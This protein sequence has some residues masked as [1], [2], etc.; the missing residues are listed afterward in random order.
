MEIALFDLPFIDIN[1]AK[2]DRVEAEH[3]T[4][5]DL[6]FDTERIDRKA[7]IDHANNAVNGI[8]AIISD[9]DFDRISDG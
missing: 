1:R 4:A 8:G 6:R 5:M 3:D 9:R 7:A 2:R